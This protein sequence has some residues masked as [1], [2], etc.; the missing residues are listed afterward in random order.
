VRGSVRDFPLVLG[1]GCEVELVSRSIR[2]SQSQAIQ[3]EDA[4]EV[5]KEHL[6]LLPLPPRRDIGFR[7]GDVARHVAS[8]LM[9]GAGYLARRGVRTAFGF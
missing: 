6:G 1:C 2:P 5:R 3:S 9:D 7:F 8:A 4:F